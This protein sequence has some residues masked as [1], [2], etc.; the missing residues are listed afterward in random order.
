MYNE[1]NQAHC[2][3]PENNTLAY[4]K[5]INL[6]LVVSFHFFI[7]HTEYQVKICFIQ[8]FYT[9]FEKSNSALSDLHY[10]FTEL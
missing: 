2:I 5:L 10:V 9:I 6:E 8:V 7:L 4:K 3:K 1:R